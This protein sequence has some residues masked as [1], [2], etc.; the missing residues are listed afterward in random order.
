MM[1]KGSFYG[2]SALP[3]KLPPLKRDSL[4]QKDLANSPD[5]SSNINMGSYAYEDLNNASFSAIEM[6]DE[7]RAKIFSCPEDWK[8]RKVEITKIRAGEQDDEDAQFEREETIDGKPVA[9]DI[10]DLEQVQ[11]AVNNKEWVDLDRY[12]ELLLDSKSEDEIVFLY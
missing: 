4:R 3:G 1:G 7:A 6:T 9:K 5:K 10:S 8:K 11:K 2:S 12:I